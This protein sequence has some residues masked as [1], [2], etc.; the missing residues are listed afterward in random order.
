MRDGGVSHDV[1]AG[2]DRQAP[3]FNLY[4]GGPS[5]SPDNN[6]VKKKNCTIN[7]YKKAPKSYDTK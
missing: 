1:R 2:L 3:L 7:N 6:T 5:R 4:R